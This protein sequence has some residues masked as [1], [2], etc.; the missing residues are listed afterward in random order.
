[1]SK[2][3][4]AYAKLNE[5][6]KTYIKTISALIK[7]ATENGLVEENERCRGKLRGYLE[8]LF[9]MEIISKTD[10]QALYL[11]FITTK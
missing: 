1:M 6:Q 11:Y 4:Q 8:C 9:Q 2:T 10:L 7:R 5:Q 3:N